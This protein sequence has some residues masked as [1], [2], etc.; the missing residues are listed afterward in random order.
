MT[1]TEGG[2]STS[3]G[4]STLPVD[5]DTISKFSLMSLRIVPTLIWKNK[6]KCAIKWLV[7]QGIVAY[8]EEIPPSVD[9]VVM[10]R[11]VYNKRTG[12]ACVEVDTDS[13]LEPQSLVLLPYYACYYGVAR[14]DDPDL[15][16]IWR[17]TDSHQ[18][19]RS[20]ASG[21]RARTRTS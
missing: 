20:T 7:K 16:D 4:W 18:R 11:L 2:S 17:V 12:R 13:G 14:D 3:V 6:E 1:E 5:Y 15:L 9:E 10:Q 21:R 8:E 19:P